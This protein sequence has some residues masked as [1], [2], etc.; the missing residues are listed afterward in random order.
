M[1]QEVLIVNLNANE[2]SSKNGTRLTADRDEAIQRY[3]P[4]L[5]NKHPS[6][7]YA[8]IQGSRGTTYSQQGPSITFAFET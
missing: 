2:F 7:D 6:T 5:S 1:F 3:V 8:I 4:P